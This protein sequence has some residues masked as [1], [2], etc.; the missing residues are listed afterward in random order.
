MTS[1]TQCR[2]AYQRFYEEHQTHKD[3]ICFGATV[4]CATL[5]NWCPRWNFVININCH[6]ELRIEFWMLLKLQYKPARW[7]RLVETMAI[8][9]FIE[10]AHT[11]LINEFLFSRFG[12]FERFLKWQRQN[13]PHAVAQDE[14]LQMNHPQNKS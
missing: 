7:V 13:N 5:A 8:T 10:S 2:D 4:F 14:D 9:H 6:H 11:S 12:P 3:P 1:P